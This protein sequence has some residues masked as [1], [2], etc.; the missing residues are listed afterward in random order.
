M[1]IPSS[2]IPQADGLDDVVLTVKAVKEGERTF[3]GIARYLGKADR[4]GHYYRRAAE[5]LGFIQNHQNNAVLTPSGREFVAALPEKQDMLLAQAVFNI[6][7]FQRMIPFFE[8]Y[9]QGVTRAEIK[10]FTARVTEDAAGSMINRR[11]TTVLNWFESLS[12]LDKTSGRYL[13]LSEKLPLVRFQDTEALMPGISD[14]K[15][16]EAVE[17]RAETAVAEMTII[18]RQADM[19]RTNEAHSNLVT[20]V[21]QRLRKADALPR[22]NRLIDLAARVNGRPYIFEMKSLTPENAHYQIRSGLSQLYEYRY[23]Q[24]LPEA[25]LVLAVETRLPEEIG[26][27]LHYLEK[28]RDICLLWDSGNDLDASEETREKMAFLR[29]VRG[30]GFGGCL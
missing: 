6:R 16:Y 4:Q 1:K 19:E 28:D 17:I 3:Q 21:A 8:M 9:P 15:A 5:L 20:L 25:T 26:W 24:A 2:D 11:V 27:M 12:V 29:G 10:A 14:L 23:L 18:K 13:L 7:I 30:E 22:Y